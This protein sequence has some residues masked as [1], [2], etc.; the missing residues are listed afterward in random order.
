MAEGIDEACFD[1][2]R[3]SGAFFV[4]ESG[5]LAVGLGAGEIDFFVGDVEVAAEEDGLSFG[6]EGFEI[7]AEGVVPCHAVWE[8]LELVL[9]VG[10][11][12]ID[13]EEV[14]I[15]ESDDA[16]FFVVFINADAETGIEWLFLGEYAS[17]GIA[18]FLSG[19][20]IG[21]VAT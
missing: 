15:L 5:A 7:G 18:G 3:E 9:R 21:L 4:G 13:E 14:G 6:F 2:R 12:D 19:I 17:T 20:P 16:S 11:V 10:R 1:Q 8:A